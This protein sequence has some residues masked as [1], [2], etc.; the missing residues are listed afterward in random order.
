MFYIAA[1]VGALPVWSSAPGGK[2]QPLSGRASLVSPAKLRLCGPGGKDRKYPAWKV[3]FQGVKAL[4]L[5]L[6]TGWL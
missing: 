2:A 3:G 5:K 6:G 4:S 1:G